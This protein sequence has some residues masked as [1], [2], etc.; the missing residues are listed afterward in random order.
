MPDLSFWIGIGIA[1]AVIVL[2]TW[3]GAMF[4]RRA[5]IDEWAEGQDRPMIPGPPGRGGE[6]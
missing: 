3:I 4:S 6:D 5:E 2:L 1:V